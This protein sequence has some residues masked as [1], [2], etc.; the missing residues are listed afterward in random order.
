MSP[1]LKLESNNSDESNLSAV[2][3]YYI[4]QERRTREPEMLDSSSSTSQFENENE[5][6]K[7]KNRMAAR[8]CRRKAKNK[9][10]LL[11][12]TSL[13][14]SQKNENLRATVNG[15]RNE[16]INLKNDILTHGTLCQSEPIQNYLT[17][18][19]NSTVEKYQS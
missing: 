10:K 8:K 4:P 16:V 1:R 7:A 17:N 11:Q 19:I 3:A 9:A 14:L 2:A 13:K 15:L 12:D 5:N 6:K 18:A